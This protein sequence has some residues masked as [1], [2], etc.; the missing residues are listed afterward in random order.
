MRIIRFYRNLLVLLVLETGNPGQD[1]PR[2]KEVERQQNGQDFV[3]IIHPCELSVTS[4]PDV[5]KLNICTRR[6]VIIPRGDRRPQLLLHQ[7]TYSFPLSF[8]H[9]LSTFWARP[10]YKCT[11]VA[12]NTKHMYEEAT[13]S[14]SHHTHSHPRIANAIHLN[15]QAF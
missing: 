2:Q 5:H 9:Y 15:T 4:N 12:K 11:Q 13:K 6:S 1:W 8:R 3:A 10:I 7:G 14:E